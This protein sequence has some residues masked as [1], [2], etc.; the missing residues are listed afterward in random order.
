MVP[1]LEGQPPNK[2]TSDPKVSLKMTET[3]IAE[4]SIYL[5]TSK[6]E[7]YDIVVGINHPCKKY[8]KNI[9]NF[10]ILTLCVFPKHRVD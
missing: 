3:S 6:Y 4:K 9:M 1:R 5:K 7:I 10:S 2:V 8:N